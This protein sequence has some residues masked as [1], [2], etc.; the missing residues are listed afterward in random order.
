MVNIF[1]VAPPRGTAT[2]AREIRVKG[3]PLPLMFE[4]WPEGFLTPSGLVADRVASTNLI[5]KPS[6]VLNSEGDSCGCLC[7][8]ENPARS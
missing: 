5:Y 4:E 6:S 7:S 1:H 3:G 8:A 2:G